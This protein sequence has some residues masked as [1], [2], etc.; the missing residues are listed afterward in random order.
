[1]RVKVQFFKID[2]SQGAEFSFADITSLDVLHRCW[3]VHCVPR[4]LGKH[5]RKHLFNAAKSVRQTSEADQELVWRMF[6][7]RHLLIQYCVDF[8]ISQPESCLR[9][10]SFPAAEERL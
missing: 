4:V 9:A 1:M 10:A 6:R 8:M 7:K 5:K 3:P 2:Y